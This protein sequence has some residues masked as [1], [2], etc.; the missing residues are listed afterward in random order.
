MSD[1]SPV[2]KYASD[3]LRGEW[4]F[5]I[6][7]VAMQLARDSDVVPPMPDAQGLNWSTILQLAEANRVVPLLSAVVLANRVK[8]VQPEAVA[9]LR[10]R[11]RHHAQR[12]MFF[13]ME[14]RN[15]LASLRQAGIRCIP[16]KGPVLTVG[17]YRKLGLRD[18]DDLDLL[19]APADVTRAVDVL[20]KLGYTGWNIPE[21]WIASHLSTESEHQLIREDS[22]VTLDLHWAVGR[23]YFTMPLDFED[24]WRRTARTKLIGAEVPDLSAEDMVLFLCYH[25]GKH[26]FG[27]LSWICDIGAT[28]AAHPD[29]DW[30]ALL[31]SAAQMG[32][33]RLLLLGLCLAQDVL[34]SVI[35]I[36]LRQ[37]IRS[38]SALDSLVAMVLRGMFGHANPTSPLKQQIAASLF[39]L[40]VR[41]RTSD[42]FRY[43]IWAV[44]PNARD[45][46]DSRLPRSLSFLLMLS[47][48]IRL[49]RKNVA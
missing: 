41:E 39:H 11:F 34:E 44:E 15:V 5:L 31:T 40:R 26:L 3:P 6:Q 18:F 21:R 30:D 12:G 33:R 42:K 9:D 1:P 35:P 43:L 25:G 24:L 27:R 47:R 4:H 2:S 29:L 20:A 13:A 48:P 45:W 36:R 49:L 14:L 22:A 37:L 17:S 23:K 19:V 46:R 10:N 16:L 38:E 8:S 28:I 7:C 32:A